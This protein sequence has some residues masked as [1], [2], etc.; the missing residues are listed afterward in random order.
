MKTTAAQNGPIAA[1]TDP[2]TSLKQRPGYTGPFAFVTEVEL[3]AWR[4]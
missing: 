4:K 2:S 3:K 1:A